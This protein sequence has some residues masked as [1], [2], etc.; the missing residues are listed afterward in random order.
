MIYVIEKQ[1]GVKEKIILPDDAKL[2]TDEDL[3]YFQSLADEATARRNRQLEAY[4][5][6]EEILK[7]E[8]Q[9]SQYKA[10]LNKNDYKRG[11]WIDGFL[12]DEEYEPVRLQ[13]QEW[14]VNINALEDEI[15]ELA[16]Q[17]DAL[18][19]QSSVKSQS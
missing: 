17:R 18:T 3:A 15:S 2:A 5:I 6:S 8:R 12:T 7:R 1:N 16:K 9:I 13:M 4:N 11:K 19:S 14:R 10:L